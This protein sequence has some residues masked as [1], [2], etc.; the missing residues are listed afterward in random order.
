MR[1]MFLKI[2]SFILFHF[3][4]L[5]LINR[6]VNRYEP[7]K[8]GENQFILP[9]VRKREFRNVQILVYH[10]VNDDGDP[11]FPA[12][13]IGVFAEQ[14]E[15]LA[16]NFNICALEDAVERMKRKDIP[17]NTVVVT[18]D[19]G[20]ADNYLYAFPILKKLSIPA[21]IFLSTGAIGTGKRL[22]HDRVF[23]AFRETKMAF[24]EGFGE[25]S[26]RYRLET[27]AEK[28]S[29]QKEVLTFLRTRNNEDLPYWID[30]LE[31]KLAVKD[32][33][34]TPGIMLDWNE[35]RLMQQDGIC[36]GSHT[37]THP[38]LSKLSCDKLREEICESKQTLETELRVSIKPFAYPFGTNREFNDH[39]KSALREAGY[40]CGVTTIF[41]ANGKDQDLFELRRGNPWEED[42][43][44]FA[45]KLNWYKFI[46]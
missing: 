31:E 11:F 29:A 35:I 32:R 20:Y 37:V 3:R 21:T 25:V 18:F 6:F 27:K 46:S 28:L 45:L 38:V 41:G 2:V 1:R 44:S 19:D 8:N 7:K 10:R 42:A 43:A 40:I 9:F 22:W 30:I 33:T 15:Y 26:K 17:D 24:F 36:F 39:T 4:A 14:M 16:S 13:P 23:S 12:T 5:G 34:E